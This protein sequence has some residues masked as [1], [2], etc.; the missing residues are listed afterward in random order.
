MFA[1]TVLLLL[2]TVSVALASSE[3]AGAA[4]QTVTNCTDS[5]PGSLRQ[6]VEQASS[7][8]TI[9]FSPSLS[10]ETISLASTV[11]IDINLTIDGPGASVLSLNGGN[12]TGVLLVASGVV[13]TISG[14]TIEE[15]SATDGGG[16]DNSGTLSLTNSVIAY[17]SGIYGGGI[18]NNGTLNVTD[19]TL[20]YNHGAPGYGGGIYNSG[21]TVTVLDSTLAVNT[22]DVAGGV[23]NV[24]GGTMS[25]T[26]STLSGNWTGLN[27]YSIYNDGA[28]LTMIHSTLSSTP[29]GEPGGDNGIANIDGSLTVTASII[30]NST[31]VGETDCSGD[32]TDGGYN[33]DDDGSCGF[34][35][36][37][38]LSDTPSGL[39]PEG[40]I[41]NGG[42]TETIALDPGSAA[43]GAVKS[44]PLC[45]TTDQRGVARPM[46]CDIGALETDDVAQ[47]ITFVSTPPADATIDGPTYAVT[48]NATSRLPVTLS[49]DSS[50][51]SV[52]SLDSTTVSFVAVGECEIDANQAG[53][54]NY[55]AAPEVQQAFHV[56]PNVRAITSASA[57]SGSV[58]KPLSFTITT[59]GSP[60]PTLHRVGKLP[61]GL[62]FT[63]NHDG[64]ATIA[65]TP[66]RVGA[67]HLMIKAIFGAGESRSVV[68]QG[69]SVAVS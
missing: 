34:D 27:G 8:D 44:A 63:D 36:S 38:D 65:G 47:T 6:A 61:K 3:E 12:A 39:D 14:L 46:P 51:T 22:A 1:A 60:A 40:L 16:I 41:D 28:T 50:S 66:R 49:I 32:I 53:D 30:A 37:T 54:Q 67:R 15:G 19:T 11:D 24:N 13:A 18:Y 9:T 21:G 17:N 45:S 55:A 57:V 56:G 58:G 23:E 68:L 42:P 20:S 26:N 5:G 52:C 7:G 43:I 4:T 31:L 33:L 48:A 35:A 25:I 62:S 2:T 10:C 69:F 29:P 59:S 64:T